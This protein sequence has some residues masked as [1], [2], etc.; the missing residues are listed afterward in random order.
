MKKQII[1]GVVE[2]VGGAAKAAP[3]AKK[4]KANA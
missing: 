4:E 1:K 2:L 3:K